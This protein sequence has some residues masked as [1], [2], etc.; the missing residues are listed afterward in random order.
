MGQV[1]K[2]CIVGQGRLGRHLAHYFS[3]LDCPVSIWSRSDCSHESLVSILA[4]VSCVL[5][6]LPDDAIESFITQH[7]NHFQG[8]WVHFSGV[9]TTSS[10]FGVHPLMTFANDLYDLSVYRQIPLV[11]TQAL[12]EGVLTEWHNPQYIISAEQKALYHAWCVL[13]GNGSCL[14]WQGFVDF[15]TDKLALPAAVAKPFAQQT[16]ANVMADP[17]AA[18]TGPLSRGDQGTLAKHQKVLQGQSAH[19]LYQ[20]FVAYYQNNQ[21]NYHYRDSL[22]NHSIQGGACED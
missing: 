16:I 22:N 17:K 15:L 7:Q 12:P 6:C 18:L 1:P 20:A 8:T 11:L 21:V 14:L 9:L 2:Y 3:L 19:A 5:L 13:A 10:A 4:S